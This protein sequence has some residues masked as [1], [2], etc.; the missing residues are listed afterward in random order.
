MM[1]YNQLKKYMKLGIKINFSLLF[2][3]IESKFI[4]ISI[5]S[6]NQILRHSQYDLLY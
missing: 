2:I 3:I 1:E 4:F 6:N 5:N